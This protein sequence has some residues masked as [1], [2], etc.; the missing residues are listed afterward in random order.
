MLKLSDLWR[1][2][3]PDVVNISEDFSPR[4]FAAALQHLKSGKAPG[5]DSVCPE[6]LIHAG[7]A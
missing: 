6:R 5:P 7:P 4:E 3:A 1:V 2:T